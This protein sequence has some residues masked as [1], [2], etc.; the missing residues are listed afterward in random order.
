MERDG[1]AKYL[2]VFSPSLIFSSSDLEDFYGRR[3]ACNF[4]E[5]RLAQ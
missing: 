1:V 4:K 3:E 5:I 2:L